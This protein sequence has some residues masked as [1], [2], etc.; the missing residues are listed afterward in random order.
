MPWRPAGQRRV[1]SV[2]VAGATGVDLT[3]SSNLAVGGAATVTGAISGATVTSA[4][5]FRGGDG[6]VAAPTFSFTSRIDQGWYS[7]AVSNMRGVVNGNTPVTFADGAS[8]FNAVT[9]QGAF[10]TNGDITIAVGGAENDWAPAGFA[11]AALVRM[12]IAAP[13]VI[14]GIAG[15][16]DGRIVVLLNTSAT[17]ATLTAEDVLSAAANRIATGVVIAAGAAQLL[18]YDGTSARWRVP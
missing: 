12:T 14:T 6:T 4:A 2:L 1:A 5:W 7:F 13:A 18:V 9:V 10:T 16:A 8:F 15:G 17:T 11:S 3:L